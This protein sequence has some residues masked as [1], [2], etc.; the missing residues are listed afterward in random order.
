MQ[1]FN[2]P[3]EEQENI[4]STY[5]QLLRSFEARTKRDNELDK[6]LVVQGYDALK[7]LGWNVSPDKWITE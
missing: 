5:W 4:L 2:I 7:K 6:L 1:K 3:K